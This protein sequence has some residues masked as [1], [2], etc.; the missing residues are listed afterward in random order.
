[1]FAGMFG[2]L[3]GSI[4]IS[5]HDERVVGNQMTLET[6][7]FTPLISGAAQPKLTADRLGGILLPVPPVAE[8]IAI[9]DYLATKTSILD[10]LIDRA[11]EAISRLTEYRQALITSAVTGKIDVRNLD[12][13]GVENHASAALS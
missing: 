9:A 4:R 3:R 6:F 11:T 1:M 7:D 2:G 12:Y 10:A 5:R 13:H 8:Q